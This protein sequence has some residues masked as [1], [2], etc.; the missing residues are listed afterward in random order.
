VEGH[1]KQVLEGMRKTLQQNSVIL[2]VEVLSDD[3]GEEITK[4][5]QIIG[6]RSIGRIGDDCRFSNF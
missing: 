3:R 2:Q 1:E 5:L 4:D 6:Y